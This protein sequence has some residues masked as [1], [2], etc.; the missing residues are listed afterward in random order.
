MGGYLPT[1]FEV[2]SISQFWVMDRRQKRKS[3]EKPGYEG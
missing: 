3:P 2:F 1:K